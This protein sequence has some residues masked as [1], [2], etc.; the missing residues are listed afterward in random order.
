MTLGEWPRR[1]GTWLCSSAVS[2]EFELTLLARG[3]DGGIP[4]AGRHVP[5]RRLLDGFG[6]RSCFINGRH[7][8]ARQAVVE[9]IALFA[10]ADN[11][12]GIG[13]G[14]ESL[15]FIEAGEGR[16]VRALR[17]LAGEG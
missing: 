9:A 12:A 3:S 11:K 1:K 13:L 2:N 15:S 14:L 17:L 8:E 7:A 4:G 5:S 6:Q 16:H 10:D